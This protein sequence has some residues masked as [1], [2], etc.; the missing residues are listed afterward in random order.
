[1]WPLNYPIY[2][3]LERDYP[4][5]FRIFN[6]RLGYEETAEYLILTVEVTW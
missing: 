5:L 1:M 6:G 3:A 4:D 2:L